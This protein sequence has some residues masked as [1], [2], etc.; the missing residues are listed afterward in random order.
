[1]LLEGMLLRPPPPPAPLGHDAE[2]A[3]SLGF[4]RQMLALWAE[5][6]SQH[7]AHAHMPVPAWL[8]SEGLQVGPLSAR[9]FPPNA[10]AGALPRRIAIPP[11]RGMS[12]G[13]GGGA[14]VLLNA[15]GPVYG[16][17][18]LP[19]SSSPPATTLHVAVGVSQL[20]SATSS[21]T[22]F[23]LMRGGTAGAP[24]LHQLGE[25]VA[26]PNLL[27][28]WTVHLGT[29][30]LSSSRLT[31]AIAHP[32][33]PIWD[34]RWAPTSLFPPVAALDGRWRWAS[35]ATL[36]QEGAVG[37]EAGWMTSASGC[38]EPASGFGCSRQLCACWQGRR[39]W[40]W[41]C[42]RPCSATAR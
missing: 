11:F 22:D 3:D 24:R 18:W 20:A 30:A 25:R 40:C 15:C 34:L 21:T 38:R 16:L 29:A 42:W 41:V 31:M 14:D 33:G 12:S 4:A 13:G 6:Y 9:I 36:G 32:F 28:L 8:A 1:M 2:E 5:D 35:D 7:H 39:R 19:A 23:E 37:G 27:Q 10:P 26:G 17:D